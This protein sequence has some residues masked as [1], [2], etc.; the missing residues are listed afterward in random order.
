MRKTILSV[1]V[2]AALVI[3]GFTAPSAGAATEVP[4]TLQIVDPAGDANFLND[5]GFA[6]TG[7]SVQGNPVVVPD[8]DDNT[9]PRDV[10]SASDFLGV[11]FSTTADKVNA[12]ILT[13]APPP[14]TQGLVYRVHTNPGEGSLARNATGCLWFEAYIAGVEPNSGQKTTYQGASSGR[15]RDLCDGFAGGATIIDAEFAIEELEDG[16]GLTTVSVDRS[17]SPKFATGEQ[18]ISPYAEVRLLNGPGPTPCQPVVGCAP[19]GV[20]APVVDTTKRG[21]DFEISGDVPP[22]PPPPPPPLK[23]CKK[24]K[25]AEGELGHGVKTLKVTDKATKKKPVVV[26]LE[27]DA[28]IG[29]GPP[30]D[31]LTSHVYQN[32]QVD[33]KKAK[34]PAGLYV[35]VETPANSDYDLYLLNPDG[36]EAAH[37]AGFNPDTRVS[38][39]TGD[40]GHSEAQA[41][42][43]DGIRSTDCQNYVADVVTATGT[44]GTLTMKLWLGKI[45]Y[46]PPPAPEGGGARAAWVSVENYL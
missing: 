30:A 43:L 13:E 5:Q 23:R 45:T 24:F 37:A 16:R 12:H 6:G 42:Q 10:G 22:P 27:A 20:T 8:T 15:L 17:V 31:V 40:G 29:S 9:T 14:A 34:K 38:D 36:T 46:P 33:V 3:S 41:E 44:G 32:M 2:M 21:L 7:V 19:T 26:E 35:R 25:P 18:I 1:A 11:W 4:A 39:G 28:G